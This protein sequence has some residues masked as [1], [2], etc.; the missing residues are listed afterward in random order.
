MQK[1]RCGR[2]RLSKKALNDAN[3]EHLIVQKKAFNDANKS[4]AEPASDRLPGIPSVGCPSAPLAPQFHDT[5][6]HDLVPGK[7]QLRN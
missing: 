2:R 4:F 6:L 7:R 5:S 1:V 3:K